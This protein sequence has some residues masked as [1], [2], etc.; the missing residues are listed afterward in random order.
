MTRVAEAKEKIR[1]ALLEWEGVTVGAHRFGGMEFRVGRRELGHLHGDSLV[2]IP[3]PMKVRNELLE[4]P[5]VMTHHIVPKSGW[6]SFA[7]ENEGHIADA[8]AL[9]R[10]SYELALKSKKSKHETH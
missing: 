1:R 6:I 5:K 3:F 4:A 10:R 9:F 2:D 7:I 8:I